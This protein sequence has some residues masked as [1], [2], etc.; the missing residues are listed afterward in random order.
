MA[1]RPQV[2]LVPQYDVVIVRAAAMLLMLMGLAADDLPEHVLSIGSPQGQGETVARNPAGLH[3]HGRNRSLRAHAEGKSARRIDA[4]RLEVAHAGGKDLYAWPGESRF[5]YSTPMEV[6]NSGMFS[7]GRILASGEG[8]V[9]QCSRR[10][11][12][13][14]AGDGGRPERAAM[15][16]H[17][18]A[19][20]QRHEGATPVGVGHSGDGGLVLGRSGDARSA[21]HRN[22]LRGTASRLS[23]RR[24]RFAD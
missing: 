23:R 11:E 2:G 12:V 24:S 15:G 4:I 21:A 10:G 18:I 17:D 13:Q 8:V 19:F 20:R 9:H 16:L 14:G 3:V 5:E 1:A 7:M 22:T 6:V